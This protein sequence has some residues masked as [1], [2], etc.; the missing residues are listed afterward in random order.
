MPRRRPGTRLRGRP[1]AVRAGG[2]PGTRWSRRD[3]QCM[4]LACSVLICSL[5]AAA[6]ELGDAEIG[7][8]HDRLQPGPVLPPH[9]L[10]GSCTEEGGVVFDLARVGATALP[11]V[12]RQV[13]LRDD[14]L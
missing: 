3:W 9:G 13:E 6:R 10:D 5:C 7:V 8:R 2:S 11:H 12:E 14:L 4:A 1:G